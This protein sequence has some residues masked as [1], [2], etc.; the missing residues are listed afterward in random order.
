MQFSAF[1]TFCESSVLCAPD[2]GGLLFLRIYIVE[3]L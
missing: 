2:V 3:T 1:V